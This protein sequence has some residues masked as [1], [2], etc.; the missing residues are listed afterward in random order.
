MKVKLTK[1][2]TK[3]AFFSIVA[4]AL[5]VTVGYF[6]KLNSKESEEHFFV[7]TKSFS[8]GDNHNWYMLYH[9]TTKCPEIRFGIRM[10]SYRITRYYPYYFCPKCMDQDQIERCEKKIEIACDTTSHH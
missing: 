2:Q 4:I 1:R 3:I 9:S 7:E 10:D 8:H 6:Y 5:A